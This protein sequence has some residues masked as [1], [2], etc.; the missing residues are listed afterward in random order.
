MRPL[1]VMAEG[2]TTDVRDGPGD[3]RPAPKKVRR[4]MTVI[5]RLAFAAASGV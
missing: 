3:V 5:K 4:R 1:S 2:R